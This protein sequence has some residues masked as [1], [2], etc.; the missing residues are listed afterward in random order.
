MSILNL[1]IA[2]VFKLN[3][4]HLTLIN[5]LIYSYNNGCLFVYLLVFYRINNEWIVQ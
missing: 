2:G 3:K 4:K 5:N 1:V